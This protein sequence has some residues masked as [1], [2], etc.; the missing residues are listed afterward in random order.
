[1]A[2]DPYNDPNR[3]ARQ[4]AQQAAD[5]A[6]ALSRQHQQEAQAAAARRNAEQQ[7]RFVQDS[8]KR[9]RDFQM[10]IRKD[11][12]SRGASEESEPDLG[13]APV[14]PR[15]GARLFALI[16]VAIVAFGAAKAFG[17]I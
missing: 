10:Q 6:Q 5:R 17:W 16:L 12:G 13:S 14:R 4:A 2:Y 9:Q 8:L 1:M 7:Q 15:R 11:M 3:F